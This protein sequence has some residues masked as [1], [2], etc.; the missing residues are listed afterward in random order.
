MSTPGRIIIVVLLCGLA[1]GYIAQHDRSIKL[2]RQ[3]TAL[4]TERQLLHDELDSVNV[5]IARL[6][7]LERLV[8]LWTPTDSGPAAQAVAQAGVHGPV[9]PGD[10]SGVPFLYAGN[11]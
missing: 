1:L 7:I 9:P 11:R 8:S 10:E 6:S 4:Q 5:N 3:L 2:T